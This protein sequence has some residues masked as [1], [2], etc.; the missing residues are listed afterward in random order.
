MVTSVFCFSSGNVSVENDIAIVAN[1]FIQWE[2][3]SSERN[4]STY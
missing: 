4:Q 3:V 1:V 2:N